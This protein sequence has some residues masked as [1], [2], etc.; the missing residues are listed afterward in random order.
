MATSSITAA[1]ATLILSVPGLMLNN[2]QIQG[3]AAEAMFETDGVENAE[4]GIGADGQKFAG[5]IYNLFPMNVTLLA[6]SQSG[7]FFENWAQGNRA[8]R[9]TYSASGIVTIPSI[10][11]KYTLVDGT[12]MSWVAFPSATRVLQPRR[13]AIRWQDIQGAPM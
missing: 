2:V 5:F 6:S 13:G 1:T 11:R 7:G 3:F 4:V 10:G 9:A 8:A 12:L